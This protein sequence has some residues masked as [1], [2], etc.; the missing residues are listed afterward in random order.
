[1][2]VVF[3]CLA[4]VAA[5]SAE[6]RF[7]KRA[8]ASP[9]SQGGLANKGRSS[10]VHPSGM[11]TF[12]TADEETGRSGCPPNSKLTRAPYQDMRDCTCN[13]G[14]TAYAWPAWGCYQKV[15]G[16]TCPAHAWAKYSVNITYN[17]AAQ[18]AQTRHPTPDPRP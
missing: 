18:V 3:C 7:N 6:E 11:A 13:T 10:G 17:R 2:K 16:F 9:Y 15:A 1:M 12:G 5:V 4:L 8:G 14:Y